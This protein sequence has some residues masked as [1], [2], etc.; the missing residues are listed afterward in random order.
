MKTP[1]IVVVVIIIVLA[2]GWFLFTNEAVAPTDETLGEAPA[3][4]TLGDNTNEAPVIETEND[5]EIASANQENK[6]ANHAT[7][8]EVIYTDSGFSPASV[9]ISAGDSVTFTNNASR[10][11]WVASA[12]HPTHSMYPEKSSDNCLGSSFDACKDLSQGESWS[13]TFNSVGSW[14]YHNHMRAVDGGTVVVK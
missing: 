4:T 10:T 9:E 12:M 11:M 13:F 7:I 5:E 6:N 2:G 3:I 1:S 14:K 8:H